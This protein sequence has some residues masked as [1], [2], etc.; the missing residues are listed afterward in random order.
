MKVERIGPER[1]PRWCIKGNGNYWSGSGWTHDAGR[2]MRYAS[3]ETAR[4][5]LDVLASGS[6]KSEG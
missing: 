5:D 2:A 6:K 4:A 3:K 1:F